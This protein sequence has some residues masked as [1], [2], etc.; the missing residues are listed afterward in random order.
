MTEFTY[1]EWI[2]E[3]SNSISNGVQGCYPREWNENHI[4]YTWLKSLLRAH[5]RVR[6]KDL[7]FDYRIG[8]DAY[9]ASGEVEEGHGDIAVLVVM[10]YKNGVELEGAGLLEAK[11]VYDSG[12]YD[13]LDWQQLEL[14]MCKTSNHRVLLYD[15][16][17]IDR[18][19][20][21]LT[22]Q[23]VCRM[24]YPLPFSEVNAG[25]I[26]TPHVLAHRSRSRS[27][28]NLSHP[29]SFQLCCRYLHGYDLDYD[30]AVVSAVKAGVA[31]GID[32]L[33]V[34]HVVEGEETELSS[35]EIE[36]SSRE[37]EPIE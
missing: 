8:W 4:S 26:P 10:H 22:A 21:K 15:H 35:S 27:I 37:F 20:K 6:I 31:D 28:H 36:I 9:K 19:V 30:E 24:C 29:L 3:V 13:A 1:H 14:Q 2:A 12:R 34:A 18:S 5:R 11:R 33:I 25:T 16:Q 32:F 7:P 23:A 17:S